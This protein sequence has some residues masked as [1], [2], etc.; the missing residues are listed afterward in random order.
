MSRSRS[1]GVKPAGLEILGIDEAEESVYR[2]LLAHACANAPEVSR[3]LQLPLGKAQRLLAAIENK[4]LSTHTP[5]RP[6]RYLP[7]SPDIAI[8]ALLLRR[9]EELDYARTLVPELQKRMAKSPGSRERMIELIASHEVE[10]QTFEHMQRVAKHEFSVLT[11]LPLRISRLGAPTSEDQTTQKEA[12]AK[13][14]RYRSIV[15]TEFL[16]APGG[17]ERILVEKRLGEEI[18][19]FP[20]LPFKMALADRHVAFI[21]LELDQA[22]SPSLLVRSSAMLNA[23]HALFELLWERAAPLSAS[24]NGEMKTTNPAELPEDAQNLITML[25]AGLNDK[26]IADELHVSVRTVRRHAVELRQKLRA[27]T[28]FQAG[29]LAA[30]RL[31][32]QSNKLM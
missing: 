23:L 29:W 14:V 5:E 3:A 32:G 30:L 15:D 25:A 31:S 12:Q 6:H 20:Q 19:V 26:K 10:Q 7:V 27:R 16:Y 24:G 9:Q 28:R 13:G 17:V 8:E 2:W 21:P 18:R 4:G 1:G 11:R 22:D